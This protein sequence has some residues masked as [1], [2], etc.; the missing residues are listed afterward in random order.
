M[1]SII[2]NKLKNVMEHIKL[3]CCKCMYFIKREKLIKV[4]LIRHGEV[5]NPK[6]IAYGRLPGYNLSLNGSNQAKI[7]SNNLFNEI[8]KHSRVKIISSPMER[9]LQTGGIIYN[10]LKT[11]FIVETEINSELTEI[12]NPYEGN[13]LIILVNSRW[14]IFNFIDSNYENYYDIYN[15]VHSCIKNI[16]KSTNVENIIIITHGELIMCMRC[17]ALKKPICLESREELQMD[18]FFPQT[19]SKTVLFF[20]KNGEIVNSKFY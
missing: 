15:R 6:Q 2:M 7:L 18:G 4:Y 19:C 12:K 9:A 13:P 1:I 17:L 10:K 5:D 8:K 3:Y 14:N 16:V 20:N 11:N